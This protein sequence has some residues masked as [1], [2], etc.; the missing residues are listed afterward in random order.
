MTDTN[1]PYLYQVLS[2]AF[3][4]GSYIFY[5]TTSR[6]GLENVPPKKT[7]TILLF[8]HGNSL[9]DPVVCIANTPRFVRFFAKDSLWK[10]GGLVSMQVKMSGAVPVYRAR[11]HGENAKAFNKDMFAAAYA[12]LH[13]GD[14]IGIA[15]EGRSTFTSMVGDLKKGFAFIAL[16][17]LDQ[18]IQ[19]GRDDY[20]IT[21]L[22]QTIL[23][24]HQ[25]K[26]RSDVLVR[27][28]VPA[29]VDK[30]WL[31]MDRKEAA[32][33]L[34]NIVREEF[35]NNLISAP[36][37]STIKLGM[38][39]S[40]IHRPLG[41]TMTLNAYMYLV[42]GWVDILKTEYPEN[43]EEKAL[44]DDLK[45]KLEQLQ[46]YLDEVK[47]KDERIRRIDVLNTRP[48]Y[49][50]TLGIVLYRIAISV[51]LTALSIPGMVIW[52]PIWITLRRAE[53]KLL[54][55]GVGWVDS[56]AQTKMLYGTAYIITLFI[57]CSVFVSLPTAVSM[58]AYLFAI[59]RLYEENVA[60]IRSICGVVRLRMISDNSL[61]E[62][63][64]LR[65]ATKGAVLKVVKLFPKYDAEGIRN[66]NGDNV[67][68]DKSKEL[69]D[70]PKWWY[71]FSPFRRRKK[72][73]NELLRFSDYCTRNYVE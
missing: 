25:E 70:P 48:S 66:D 45:S 7:P 26:F 38:T 65:T 61:K 47:V 5:A 72:D 54:A 50:T 40:R 37:F 69:L 63:L 36:E 21:I 33:K 62:I 56:I 32:T 68:E 10:Q 31:K 42:H 52:A 20:K 67:Y 8:N 2:W 12:A 22:T 30:E 43:S 19:Q 27:Y 4:T 46:V 58:M 15:P 17:A 49:S 57:L 34:T 64:E 14:C 29:I 6:V 71:N 23:F 59:M 39:A 11:D 41:T 3:A 18:A 73:W 55:K 13:N 28:F 51:V 9:A 44:V 1:A 24:T 53:R 35:R 60:N 16:E